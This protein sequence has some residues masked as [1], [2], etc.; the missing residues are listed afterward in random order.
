MPGRILWIRPPTNRSAKFPIRSALD[1]LR[2]IS[3]NRVTATIRTTT[4]NSAG[5]Q[6]LLMSDPDRRKAITPV[7]G[8]VRV[9]NV[10]Q[11]PVAPIAA[12]ASV[13]DAR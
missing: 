1:S 10:A 13:G 11:T 8:S 6:Y 7:T 4:P 3:V 2:R 12:V 5:N 9:T